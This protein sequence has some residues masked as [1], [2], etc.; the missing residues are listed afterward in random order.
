MSLDSIW[1]RTTSSPPEFP[2]LAGRVQADVAIV[3]GG[4][5]GLTCAH[6][7]ARA[8]S[9]VVLVEARRIGSGTTGRSTGNLYVAIDEHLSK[10]KSRWGREVAREVV[11][12][13]AHAIDLI[14]SLVADLGIDC[15]FRRVSFNY[16]TEKRTRES[17]KFLENETRAALDLDLPVT[18]RSPGD[19]PFPV[20][21]V[22][23]IPAQAQ[24]HPLR[25]AQGLGESLRDKIPIFENSPVVDFD[26]ESKSLICEGGELKAKKI[27]FATHVP[28]GFVGLQLR[29]SP[30]REHGAAAELK[31]GSAFEG[32]FW[33]VERPARSVRALD[34]GG[35]HYVMVIGDKFKTGHSSDTNANN[36]DLDLYLSERFALRDTRIFWS[37]QSYR[38]A[39]GLPYIGEYRPGI[40]HL[41]GFSTDGL[42]Y[43]SLGAEIICEKI[44]G[45][46]SPWERLYRATRKDFLKA[47][48]GIAREG[49]DNAC[50]Y[51]R[52][53][54]G[55][56]AVALDAIAPGDGGIVDF[57]GAKVAVYR[58]EDRRVSALSAVCTHMKCIVTFN[59]AERTWDCPCHASRFD[60]DGSVL[61]GPALQPLKPVLL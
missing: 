10:L 49:L 26:L 2:R 60:L 3:G 5:S 11:R 51:L 4:L 22:L 50:Q 7:L 24:F 52:N 17:E 35:R 38:S 32:I 28:K 39:D 61:E 19:L 33:R 23:E 48:P 41:T 6:L 53:V 31:D 45:R 9:S 43:G 46:E 8:G 1:R 21:R 27:I 40:F 56:G 37:A 25:Y 47:A 54:P 14:E 15:S 18:T 58:R 44:L 29:L 13:R 36:A 42:T 57:H 55:V 16:F 20:E 34:A 30:I 12:S 59:R